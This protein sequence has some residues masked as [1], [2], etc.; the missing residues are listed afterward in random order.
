MDKPTFS[1]IIPTYSRPQ[2]LAVCLEAIAELD[3]PNDLFEVIVVDD[4][5]KTPLDSVVKSF[6]GKISLVLLQQP[7]AGPANARNNGATKANGQ[8]LAFTDDDCV[9]SSAWLQHLAK[10][11]TCSPNDMIGGKV[12]NALTQNPYSIVSQL[13][14]DYLYYYNRNN[15]EKSFFT[16]NNVVVPS[17]K[18]KAIN[19][20]SQKFY[21]FAGA[22]DREFCH[23]WLQT[24]Q[25]KTYVPEALVYH[26]HSLSFYRFCI[27]HFNYGRG[28]FIFHQIRS[29]NNQDKNINLEPLSFY[30]NLILY[31][32]SQYKNIHAIFFIFLMVVSQFANT[33][34]FFYEL[35]ATS[36]VQHNK[37]S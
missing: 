19:G 20:F 30:I 36:F 21:S 7:N 33:A 4:G 2:Q 22:E 25:G 29:Q 13:L 23:R 35:I 24:G 28:A 6:Q 16:T 3:Y 14:V 15:P 10:Q 26:F 1:I 5:S 18:F 12:I 9:P 11:I 31:P 32:L 8:Y 37:K 17:N 27:Q 34:G